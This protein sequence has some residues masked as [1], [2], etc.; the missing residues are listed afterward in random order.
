MQSAEAEMGLR[1]NYGRSC[2]RSLK[3]APVGC[4]LSLSPLAGE[5]LSLSIVHGRQWFCLLSWLSMGALSLVLRTDDGI[6]MRSSAGTPEEARLLTGPCSI[7]DCATV[8]LVRVS[9]PGV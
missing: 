5:L 9:L 8:R 2:D 1:R 3:I 4:R 6:L 7:L